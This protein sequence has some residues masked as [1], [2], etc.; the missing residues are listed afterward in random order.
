MSSGKLKCRSEFALTFWRSANCALLSG[1]RTNQI[2]A[3]TAT[4]AK[5]PAT[6]AARLLVRK[7][8]GMG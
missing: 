3:A 4:T 5:T 1:P 7:E 6:M 2:V 8:T